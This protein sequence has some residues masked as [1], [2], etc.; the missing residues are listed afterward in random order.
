MYIFVDT[1]K[2]FKKI[3]GPVQWI[4]YKIILYLIFFSINLIKCIEN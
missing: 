3:W 2:L 1:R 4:G